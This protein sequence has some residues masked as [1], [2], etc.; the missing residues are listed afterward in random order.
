MVDSDRTL[1]LRAQ[2]G[3]R[4]SFADLFGRHAVR[5]AR[6]GYLLLHDWNAA[7]DVLQ[8][9][10]L[11]GWTKVA[12]YA[13]KAPPR[14]WLLSIALNLVRNTIRDGKLRC[15]EPSE[16]DAVHAPKRGV[17]T[18]VLRRET[19]REL[20]VA[21]GYLTSAQREVFVLHYIE[22]MPYEEIAPM[23]GISIDAARHLAHRAREILRERIPRHARARSGS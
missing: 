9:T 5:V 18:S 8:E 20:A 15:T 11:R 10:F 4:Q 19:G 7:E 22:E 6:L 13:G 1:I 2:K 16:L 14:A 23:R 21:L 17:V 12:S 3:D